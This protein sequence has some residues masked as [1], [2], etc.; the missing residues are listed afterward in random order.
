[1]IFDLKK[2]A[3]MLILTS[4]TQSCEDV[5]EI[6]TPSTPPRLAIDALVRVDSSMPTTT[7]TIKAGVTSSF[8]EAIQAVTLEEIA[9]VSPDYVPSSPVDERSL[10]L[11][12]VEPGVYQ[13]TKDTSFFT[14]G[15]LQLT[16]TYDGQNYLAL[17]EYVPSAQIQSVTQGDASLFSEEDIEVKISFTD[18][19]TIENFYLFDFGLG[20]YLVTEDEFYQGETFNFS[21]FIEDGAG[22]NVN[23]ALLGVTEP[24]YNYMN[25]IIVQGGGDQ[26]PF[27]TPAATVR[28]NIINVTGIDD[29]DALNNIENTDDFALGYFAV[30]EVFEESILLE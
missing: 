16:L 6:E 12:E 2:L 9:I 21:Y 5:V 18:D 19:G 7:V 13:G 1:M 8:F 27:Q 23:I 14:S 22:R 28:G 26:G 25:Q 30:C 15:E 4:L 11:T 17:T 24:F 20:D 29:I 10:T 3:L